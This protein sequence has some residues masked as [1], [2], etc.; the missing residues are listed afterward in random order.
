MAE[1]PTFPQEGTMRILPDHPLALTF[2]LLRPETALAAIDALRTLPGQ[3]ATEGL[4]EL[5][6]QSPSARLATAAIAALDGREGAIVLDALR[7]A[8]DSPHVTVRLAAILA[9]HQR[10]AG[11]VEKELES[12]LRGD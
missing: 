10:Q 4:V 9:L 8:L 11:Q 5:I 12:L 1:G 7:A 2:A 3:A 6:A